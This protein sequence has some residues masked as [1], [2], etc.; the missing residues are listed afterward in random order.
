VSSALVT[1]INS[2]FFSTLAFPSRILLLRLLL[3][4]GAA[5]FHF[6]VS[7]VS[8]GLS[9]INLSLILTWQKLA[10]FLLLILCINLKDSFLIL[11][12]CSILSSIFGAIQGISQSSLRKILA[13]S[14]INHIGWMLRSLLI[15]ISR[16]LVYFSFYSIILSTLIYL[17]YNLNLNS[18]TNTRSLHK[19]ARY[20]LLIRLI[21]LGGL[22]PLTGFLPKWVIIVNL[23][24]LSIILTFFLIL[25][26]LITLWFYLRLGIF[27]LSNKTISVKKIFIPITGIPIILNLSGLLLIP[28]II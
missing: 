11:I 28:L 3:K 17:A 25:S 20:T 22:P 10:P 24:E 19:Y 13:F 2:S 1:R 12:I 4:L 16:W 8:E 6:W 15:K 7:P 9:W 5:P 27:S 18:L 23:S 14:S 21:S 26:R